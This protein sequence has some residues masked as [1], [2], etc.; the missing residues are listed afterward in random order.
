MGMGVCGQRRDKEQFLEV[1]Q[2]EI[3]EPDRLEKHG[4]EIPQHNN[5]TRVGLVKILDNIKN[6]IKI[7]GNKVSLLMGLWKA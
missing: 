3:Q 5:E 6:K 4:I 2:F 1:T 7:L